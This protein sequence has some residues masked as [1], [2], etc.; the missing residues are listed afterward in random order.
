MVSEF[1]LDLGPTTWNSIGRT[2]RVKKPNWQDATSNQLVC[3]LG[4]VLRPTH[5]ALFI[6]PFLSFFLGFRRPNQITGLSG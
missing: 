3:A 4:I 1:W 5:V 2:S 6:V